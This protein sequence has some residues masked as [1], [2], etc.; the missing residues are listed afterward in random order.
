MKSMDTA[1]YFFASETLAR[2]WEDAGHPERAL[3]ILEEVAED[4]FAQRG[5]ST[6]SRLQ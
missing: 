2:A 5:G 4:L 3:R 6:G 1:W